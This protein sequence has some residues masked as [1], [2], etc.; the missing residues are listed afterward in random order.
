MVDRRK[1]EERLSLLN[2]I[3]TDSPLLEEGLKRFLT[4][5]HQLKVVSF[6]EMLKSKTP[7]QV[8]FRCGL[9]V[10]SGRRFTNF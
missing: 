10:D 4:F 5:A 7:E 9:M 1:S 2:S 3:G 6:Y 8:L